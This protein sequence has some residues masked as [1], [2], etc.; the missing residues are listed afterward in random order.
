M[1]PYFRYA[2]SINPDVWFEP[3]EVTIWSF[4]SLW[5]FLLLLSLCFCFPYHIRMLQIELLESNDIFS[6]VGFSCDFIWNVLSLN[7]TKILWPFSWPFPPF[8]YKYWKHWGCIHGYMQ[9]V[10]FS[11]LCVCV[12][13]FWNRVFYPHWTVCYSIFAQIPVIR[14]NWKQQFGVQIIVENNECSRL[15]KVFHASVCNCFPGLGGESCGLDY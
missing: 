11:F 7:N 15:T 13:I 8:L 14:L 2:D 3:T 12:I 5:P 6:E 10:F 9:I 1:Q 4:C